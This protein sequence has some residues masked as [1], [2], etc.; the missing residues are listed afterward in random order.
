MPRPFYST[1]FEQ[2]ADRVWS[3][4]RD[5]GNY[6]WA[7][8]V[9]ETHIEDGKSGDSVGCIRN[10]RTN[11]NTL[12][13]QLL[14][15]SDRDRCYTY[16][17]CR[18]A[19]LPAAQLCGDASHHADHR[20]RPIIRRMVGGFRLHRQRAR[21]LDGPFH[22]FVPQMARSVRLPSRR[23]NTRHTNPG[24]K[25]L[26]HRNV[27]HIRTGHISTGHMNVA[28]RATHPERHHH[29]WHFGTRQTTAAPRTPNR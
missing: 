10:V 2:S 25:N 20:R 17:F 12:R 28:A 27:G 15:H 22:H 9:S 21:P 19:P 8:V 11:G 6:G 23:M 13:Q 3:A 4:I 16:A 14:A 5:F 1:V 26:A 24:H 7:G 18:T 29:S